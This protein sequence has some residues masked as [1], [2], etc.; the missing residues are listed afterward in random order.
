MLWTRL[1]LNKVQSQ[2]QSERIESFDEYYN[3][4][5]LDAKNLCLQIRCHVCA[6]TGRTI[7][8]NNTYKQKT[9]ALNVSFLWPWVKIDNLYT[10]RYVSRL[11]LCT[12][13]AMKNWARENLTAKISNSLQQ[14]EMDMS[15]VEREHTNEVFI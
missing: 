4:R 6:C 3:S 15:Q 7:A 12:P 10:T 2:P 13:C 11:T 8:N 9:T 5:L 14:F 1:V